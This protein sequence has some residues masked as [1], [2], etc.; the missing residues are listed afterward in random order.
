MPEEESYV[1]DAML[2]FIYSAKYEVDGNQGNLA[3]RLEKTVKHGQIGLAGKKYGIPGLL[4]YAGA[5][6]TELMKHSEDAQ[7]WL[8]SQSRQ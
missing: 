1:V 5:Q 6:V 2:Q 4:D 3:E 7:S 8:R